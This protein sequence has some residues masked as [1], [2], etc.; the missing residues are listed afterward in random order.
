[1]SDRRSYEQWLAFMFIRESKPRPLRYRCGALD[2]LPVLLTYIKRQSKTKYFTTFSFFFLFFLFAFFLGFIFLFSIF[3]ACF[4]FVLVFGY[5]FVFQ[6]YFLGSEGCLCDIA[7]GAGGRNTQQPY[8][9]IVWGLNSGWARS[10][11]GL[12]CNIPLSLQMDR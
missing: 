12:S 7:S 11:R 1:M 5:F 2:S 9:W 4:C 6:L 10:F 8:Y 3:L